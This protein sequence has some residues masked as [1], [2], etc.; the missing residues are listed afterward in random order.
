MKK[1]LSTLILATLVLSVVA[2]AGVVPVRAAVVGT[3]VVSSPQF[4]YN[5]TVEVYL[6]DPDLLG[7]ENVTITYT[8]GSSGPY[9]M[10]LVS[11]LKNGEFY[12]YFGNITAANWT[13]GKYGYNYTVEKKD[14]GTSATI[15]FKYADASPVGTVTATVDYD[16]Y[17]ASASDITFDRASLEYP[18][19]GWIR[20]FIKDYDYNL[21]STEVESVD[22]NLLFYNV[23]G[24]LIG[25]I[26]TSATETDVATGIFQLD[27]SYNTSSYFAGNL[28]FAGITSGS[29]I[30]VVYAN[31]SG[32]P[33]KWITLKSFP[34]SLVVAPSFTTR[35]DLT[36]T[37]RDPNLNLKSWEQEY[38]NQTIINTTV[39][40]TLGTD[41]VVLNLKETDK[42]TGEFKA[43]VPVV[44]GPPNASD[45][46]LQFNLTS[47]KA[48]ID[49]YFNGT[50]KAQA[51]STLSTTAATITSDKTMYRKDAK[52]TLTLTAP[53]INDDV[54]NPNFFT[55]DIDSNVQ[56]K[57]LG[58]NYQTIKVGELTIKVNGLVANSSGSQ[59]LTFV[60]T[61]AD[62]GK[63][64]SSL[65]LT[66]IVKSDGSALTDGDVIVVSYYDAINDATASA[67]FTIGIPAA[68]ISLDRSTYP[69]PKDD[70]ISVYITVTDSDRNKDSNLIET[71]TVYIEVYYY[72]GTLPWNG[73]KTVKE[74]GPNTG[75]FKYTFSYGPNATKEL[76]NGWIKVLYTDPASGNNVTATAIFRATDAMISVDK[77]TVKAG[78]KLTITVR[79]ADKNLD[80]GAPDKVTVFYE[81]TG[82][83]GS[84]NKGNWSLTETDVNTGVFTLSKTIGSDIKVK[85]GSTITFTYYDPT[86]SYITAAAGYPSDPVE[87]TASAKVATFTGEL[88]IDKTEYGLGSKMK[89]TVTDPDLNTDITAI[90]SATVTLR[91]EGV[92]DTSITLNEDDFNSGV[93]TGTYP[94]GT[95]KS[96][97]GKTF[98]VYYRDVANAAGETV[99]A[100]ATGTIKSWDGA[101]AF[102]KLY[103][104]LGE[105]A[106]ITV[107]DP[108]ANLD[109]S[110]IET[111][112]ITVVS[113][114]DPLGQTITATETGANTG[115]FEGRIQ[116]SNTF[117]TGKVFAKLGDTVT[118]KYKDQYPA[119]YAVTEKSKTFTG[120]AVVG[121]PIARP[122]PA[123]SQKFVDPTTGAEKTS[124][125]VGQAI[126]LQA[127]LKNVDATSKSFTAI[128]KVKDSAGVTI[129]ISWV[130]GTL[131]AGQE[132]SPAVS[133]TPSAAGTYTVD[134][135]VVKSLA[136]PTPYS[137][138][139][140]KTLVV[141]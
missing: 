135:L 66:K 106:V 64:T 38:I 35:D 112:Q 67:T 43:T 25:N 79:D 10:V 49:Y 96:L 53:D 52:V 7:Q 124:G 111:I 87:Y 26:T 138:P 22:I 107:T 11:P 86:P 60:E 89:I 114:S 65:N 32:Q 91:I 69:L 8:V 56:I 24:G 71:G 46:N 45:P 123:S 127:T 113:D 141:A 31:E 19:N 42:D 134:V 63:F 58:V 17:V 28:S 12:G 54:D 128:F 100:M 48:Q 14:L 117:A 29:P 30:K 55:C 3:L 81:Y 74:S 104:D 84:T 13:Y 76:I 6:N 121:V 62:T 33:F 90:D 110:M 51:T 129:F 137:D 116:I 4:Y 102:N 50:L 9:P 105:V 122:V 21:N 82:T 70:A 83:D 36:I 40:V 15:T 61:G 125:T 94:W 47:T 77:T 133:W 120:T 115:V 98:M 132:L 103:Y 88:K 44:I 99:Y 92:G 68:T 72:N 73:T 97:I 75:I 93:F 85:P 130:T 126:M 140:S 139:L 23:T 57:S 118:A 119:D 27:V 95:D 101:V 109:P 34:V 108:D 131:A 80:S 16:E 78:D 59:T 5:G 39:R 2:V 136:E 18:M 41:V 37:L 1:V 20:I